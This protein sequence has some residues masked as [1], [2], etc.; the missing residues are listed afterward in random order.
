MKIAIHADRPALAAAAAVD[1]ATILQHT[2]AEQ[3]RAT[4]VVA[5]GT[6]QLEVLAAFAAADIA[7]ERVEFFH[8]D[9]YCGLPADHPA[10]FRRYLRE[11][12]FDLLP[13][14]PAAF[15]WIEAEATAEHECRRLAKL[16]PPGDFD[17]MLCGIGENAHLAFND[18]PADFEA[19]DPYRVV[20]LDEACRRQQVGEGWF[21]TFDDVPTQ[22]IS[23]SIRRILAARAIICSVPDARKAAAVRD[24]VRGPVTP[25]VPASILQRHADCR[26]HVDRAAAAFLD[27]PLVLR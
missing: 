13:R 21:A 9:E 18:P 25:Q 20:A 11:R 26:L 16:V 8:L 22:A 7:W 19:A 12:F 1:A 5:T 23:M 3:S 10:S 24:S 4:V 15:H 27:H 2:L 6:S 14:R 17:L